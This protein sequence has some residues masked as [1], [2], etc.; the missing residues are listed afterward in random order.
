MDHLPVANVWQLKEIASPLEGKVGQEA[1]TLTDT[2]GLASLK[3]LLSLNTKL[4]F[5][6]FLKAGKE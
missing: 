6:H 1:Q 5:R 2:S 3:C 4:L